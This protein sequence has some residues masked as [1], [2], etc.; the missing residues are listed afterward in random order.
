SS[1]ESPLLTNASLATAAPTIPIAPHNSQAGKKAPNK[2]NDGA[3]LAEQPPRQTHTRHRRPLAGS[4]CERV[5]ISGMRPTRQLA[6]LAFWRCPA[7]RP[8]ID[9]QGRLHVGPLG[10]RHAVRLRLLLSP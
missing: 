6:A 3:P 5:V 2:S 4:V 10:R 8:P 1:S 9:A 7:Q